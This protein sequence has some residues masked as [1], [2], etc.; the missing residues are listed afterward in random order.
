MVVNGQPGV[1][2]EVKDKLDPKSHTDNA[3]LA[4]IRYVHPMVVTRLV[5]PDLGNRSVLLIG[6]PSSICSRKARAGQS[7]DQF[8]ASE[9]IKHLGLDVQAVQHG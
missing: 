2:I 5:L 3:A 8:L 1:P 7:L 9:E 6:L 4:A